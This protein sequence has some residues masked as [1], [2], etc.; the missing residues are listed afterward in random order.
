MSDDKVIQN[1]LSDCE[2]NRSVRDSL[3]RRQF[4]TRIG[5][6]GGAALTSFPAIAQIGGGRVLTLPTQQTKPDSSRRG[7]R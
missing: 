7:H 4:L 3:N 5:T 2:E 6:L 1:I